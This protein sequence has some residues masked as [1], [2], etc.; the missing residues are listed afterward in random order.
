MLK[1]ATDVV[2]AV[3]GLTV[4]APLLLIIYLLLKRQDDG[5]PLFH[6][7]RIGRFGQPFR[8]HKFRTMRPDA[9]TGQP[10]L[11]SENDERLTEIGRIL[12][13][14]HLDELPQ[15]WNVLTGEMSMVGP[16]P[17]RRYFIRKIEAAGEDYQPLLLLRP[18][19]TSEAT[20]RNGYTDTVEK[21]RVRLRMDRRYLRRWSWWKDFFIL[22]RTCGLV[23]TGDRK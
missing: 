12:R 6:Q 17:E 19:V 5:T 11:A 18:G 13:R 15:L 9:E 1:R 16:R 21:M 2:C 7:E 3:I 8:I 14:H 23:T 10:L 4:C 20:L 22:L